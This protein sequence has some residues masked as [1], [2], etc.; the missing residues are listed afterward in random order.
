MGWGA[1]LRP[2]ADKKPN[3]RYPGVPD[4]KGWDRKWWVREGRQVQMLA[5]KNC[6]DPKARAARSQGEP[7]ESSVVE[8]QKQTSG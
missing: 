7:G 5:S 6:A 1:S 8:W 4:S 2:N 3:V